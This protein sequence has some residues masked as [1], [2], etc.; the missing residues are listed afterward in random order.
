MAFFFFFFFSFC[1]SIGF[2]SFCNVM[3][4]IFYYSFWDEQKNHN[5]SGEHSVGY[6]EILHF[7]IS[8]DR[9]YFGCNC[10]FLDIANMYMTIFISK[11]DTA[12]SKKK[13]RSS[14][15]QTHGCKLC[16]FS[17]RFFSRR[18]CQN[19]VKN[20]CKILVLCGQK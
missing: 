13:N 7:D 15:P 18:R 16:Y 14:K 11:F 17:S 4:Y 2:Q 10:V 1:M 19:V 20:L 9:S 12:S 3:L 6:C 8:S 5:V